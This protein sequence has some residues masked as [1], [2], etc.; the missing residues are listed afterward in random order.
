MAIEMTLCLVDYLEKQGEM[1]KAIS[2]LELAEKLV[3]LLRCDEIREEKAIY[4]VNEFLK[5]IEEKK[6]SIKKSFNM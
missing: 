1:K 2:Q 5:Y 4:D 6:I 3:F